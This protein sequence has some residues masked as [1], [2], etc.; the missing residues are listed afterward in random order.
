MSVGSFR[1][2]CETVFYY[3]CWFDASILVGSIYFQLKLD[4]FEWYTPRRWWWGQCRCVCCCQ[5]APPYLAVLP[6]RA[7]TPAAAPGSDAGVESP[8]GSVRKPGG[9]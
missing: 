2:S 8:P 7:Q 5:A 4:T 6:R 9:Y 3:A 1:G